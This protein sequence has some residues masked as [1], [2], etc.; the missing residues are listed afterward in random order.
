MNVKAPGPAQEVLTLREAAEY[1]RISER[2][3]WEM[4]NKNLLPHFRVGSSEKKQIRLLLED[5]RQ[6]AKN[7]S[8]GVAD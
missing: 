5:L 7:Q 3:A 4:V 2:L 1:L 6:W 8:G